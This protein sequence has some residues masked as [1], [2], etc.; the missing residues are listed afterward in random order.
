LLLSGTDDVRKTY[1]TT[2]IQ[3]KIQNLEELLSNT[4][5]GTERHKKCLSGLANWYESK[6]HRTKDTS[7]IKESI[8]YRRLSLDATHAGDPMENHSLTS[9]RNILF[10]AF[11]ETRKIGYLN[12]SIAIDYDILE[13]KPAAT[14]TTFA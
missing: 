12:E 1:S 10:L 6:F 9:L 7:D 3:Q 2:A 14:T 4:P 8:K 5:P 13:L 11:E